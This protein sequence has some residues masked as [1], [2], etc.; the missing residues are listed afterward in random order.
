MGS[1]GGEAYSRYRWHS[2]KSITLQISRRLET[3]IVSSL[4]AKTNQYIEG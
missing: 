4:Y 1:E 3:V 2:S